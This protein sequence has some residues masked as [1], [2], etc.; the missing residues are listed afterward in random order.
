MGASAGA[1]R[2]GA[3][4]DGRCPPEL[5]LALEHDARAFGHERLDAL[6]TS[7]GRLAEDQQDRSNTD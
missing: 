2:L 5:D 7:L 6:E 4:D 1:G 3:V